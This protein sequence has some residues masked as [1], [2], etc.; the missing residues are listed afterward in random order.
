[1]FGLKLNKYEYFSQVEVVGRGAK[2]NFKWVKLSTK[3]VKMGFL[4]VL[5]ANHT[6][7]LP[8]NTKKLYNIVEMLYKCFVFAGKE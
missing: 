6:T 5:S 3:G 8:A 4:T 2:H 1:M 7:G